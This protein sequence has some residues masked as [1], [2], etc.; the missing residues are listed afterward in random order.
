MNKKYNPAGSDSTIGESK[1]CGTGSFNGI[2]ILFLIKCQRFLF[3]F[4]SLTRKGIDL[5]VQEKFINKSVGHRDKKVYNKAKNH[6]E[7]AL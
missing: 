1:I 5:P 7:L 2:I 6:I 4:F 3:L